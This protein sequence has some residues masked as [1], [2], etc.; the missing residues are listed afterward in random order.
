[1]NINH[2]H[3]RNCIA[4]N[5][6]KVDRT[7]K[8]VPKV[9]EKSNLLADIQKSISTLSL[10]MPSLPDL[11]LPEKPIILKKPVHIRNP[12]SAV[13]IKNIFSRT[14]TASFGI[15]LFLACASVILSSYFTPCYEF[16]VEGLHIGYSLSPTAYAD[17]LSEVNTTLAQSFGEESTIRKQ[18][19]SEFKLIRRTDL[20]TD[21]QF[22]DNISSLSSL[23]V[24][25]E[26]MYA[27]GKEVIGFESAE[28]MQSA[29]KSYIESISQENSK[30]SIISNITS[31]RRYIPASRLADKDSINTILGGADGI[32]VQTVTSTTYTEPVA[33]ATETLTDDTA[34][35]GTS[36]VVTKGVNGERTVTAEVICVNGT[37]LS[38]NV[39]SDTVTKQPVSEVIRMG[40]KR[41]PTGVGSGSFIFPTTGTISSRFGAR[42]NRQHKGLDIANAVGTDIMASDE[43]VVTYSGVMNGYG[44]IIIIDHKNGYKTYYAHCDELFSKKGEIVEKGEVIAAM[45]N[46]GNSTGP[47]L[48]FEVREDDTPVNP[49]NFVK[50]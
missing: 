20:S 50:K 42:W 29:I 18:S 17:A 10:Q 45:G 24:K 40:T 14:I 34:Y 28:E 46:T 48:H 31:E 47:H 19:E 13:L 16:T 21:R 15:I 2:T 7:E 5:S 36:E 27:D 39:L 4:S 33:Y 22:K 12:I 23:M 9:P 38:R 3:A 41:I 25:A 44:N 26:V 6:E 11:S 43:G 49:E 37:E 1:M 30:V 32:K 35:T 8:P